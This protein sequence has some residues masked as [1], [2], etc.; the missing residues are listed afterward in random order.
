VD[1]HQKYS[2]Y[3]GKGRSLNAIP[4][5]TY[6][7]KSNY[8][9]Y[10]YFYDQQ[11]DK[12]SYAAHDQNIGKPYDYHYEWYPEQRTQGYNE[13]P[14]RYIYVSDPGGIGPSQNVQQNARP[15]ETGNSNSFTQP[16]LGK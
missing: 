3:E 4:Q 10:G 8:D 12:S 6:G 15:P 2:K 9:D 16:G 13:G 14:P 1:E 5:P 7:S 11:Y